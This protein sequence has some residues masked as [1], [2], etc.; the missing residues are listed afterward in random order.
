MANKGLKEENTML[1]FELFDIEDEEEDSDELL[2]R[3]I[4]F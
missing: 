3:I 4:Y 2:P 1:E